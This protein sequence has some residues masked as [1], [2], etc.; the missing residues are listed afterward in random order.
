[1]LSKST[2]IWSRCSR[3]QRVGHGGTQGTIRPLHMCLH[4]ISSCIHC[5]GHR[6]VPLPFRTAIAH[7]ETPAPVG[8]EEVALLRQ[9]WH[10]GGGALVRA[11]GQ[12]EAGPAGQ[13]EAACGGPGERAEQ[14]GGREHGAARGGPVRHAPHPPAPEG[15]AGALPLPPSSAEPSPDLRQFRSL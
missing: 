1:M 13:P 5:A 3:C 4:T 14:A 11:L 7:R 8:E 2:W 9:G 6:P 15:S 10:A 12:G